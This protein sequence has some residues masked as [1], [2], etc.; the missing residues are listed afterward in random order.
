MLQV[1]INASL[2]ATF[3]LTGIIFTVNSKS[4]GTND[5]NKRRRKENNYKEN[6]ANEHRENEK[7]V[8]R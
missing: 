1:T 6:R 7:K 3:H 4:K 8:K 5:A 2:F